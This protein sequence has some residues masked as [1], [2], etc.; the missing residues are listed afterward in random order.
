MAFL[1]GL[2]ARGRRG[3]QLVTSDAHEGRRQARGAV[4]HGA[5]WQRYRAHVLR[6][7]LALVPKAAPPLVAATIRTVFAQPT[8]EAA[9]QQGRQGADS[10]RSRWPHVAALR[11]E[12]AADLFAS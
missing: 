5:S 1:R 2:V 7:A 12:A 6:N 4:L 9:R 11:D 10:F 3:V 8:A